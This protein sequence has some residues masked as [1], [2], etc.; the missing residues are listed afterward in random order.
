MGT[1]EKV[2]NY[3]E[4]HNLRKCVVAKKAGIPV[5]AL[6][7]LL[8]G[9]RKMYPEDLRSICYAL[10]VSAATFIERKSDSGNMETDI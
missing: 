1:Y 3:I 4:K 10:N 2:R 5:T 7:A 8:N 6:S 9:K